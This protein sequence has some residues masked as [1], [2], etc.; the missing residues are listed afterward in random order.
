MEQELKEANTEE[1]NVFINMTL[2]DQLRHMKNEMYEMLEEIK[3][4]QNKNTF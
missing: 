2:K 3:G 1:F 4:I